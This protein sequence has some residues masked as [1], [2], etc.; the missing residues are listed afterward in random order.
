M[1]ELLKQRDS[2]IYMPAK[3]TTVT[4]IK[5]VEIKLTEKERIEYAESLKAAQKKLA[6]LEAE[7]AEVKKEFKAKLD[8]AKSEFNKT[9]RAVAHGSLLEEKANC[10]LKWTPEKNEIH[11][12]YI[13]RTIEKRPPQ[14]SDEKL[15]ES[16]FPE[17]EPA[18][19]IN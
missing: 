19:E 8:T 11:I 5:S 10:E 1:N 4:V 13:G 7:F 2:E 15:F 14:K 6:D 9:L 3:D 17:D 16:L 12:T 18:R